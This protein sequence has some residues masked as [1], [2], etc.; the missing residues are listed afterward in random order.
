MHNSI[1]GFLHRDESFYLKTLHKSR[2]VFFLFF[3]RIGV[4]ILDSENTASHNAGLE[5]TD[6]RGLSEHVQPG[7]LH[8]AA[9]RAGHFP[10]SPRVW[11]HACGWVEAK[12]SF[13]F[14]Q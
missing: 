12:G 2:K 10:D 9:R 6:V 8:R 5:N 14:M 7:S 11:D 3:P 1:P 13:S 4:F